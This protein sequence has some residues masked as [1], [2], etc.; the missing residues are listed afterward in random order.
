MR[1]KT[2]FIFIVIIFLFGCTKTRDRDL[3]DVIP[4]AYKDSVITVISDNDKDTEITKCVEKKLKKDLPNLTFIQE[5]EFRDALYPWFEPNTAPKSK[6]QLSNLLSTPL[7]RE[8]IE[9]L[10]LRYLIYVSGSTTQG[11]YDGLLTTGGPFAGYASARRKTNIETTV[12]DIKEAVSIGGTNIDSEGKVKII[13][14]YLPI[15]IPAD[16]ESNACEETAKRISDMLKGE[17]L[18]TDK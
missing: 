7:V 18:K 16:T 14:L 8:R 12:W 10:S 17:K 11:E 13:G 4:F 3:L 9:N 15:I 6:Q 5:D 1:T 2:L